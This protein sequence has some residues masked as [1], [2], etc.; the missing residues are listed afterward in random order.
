MRAG[1]GRQSVVGRRVGVAGRA[2]SKPLQGATLI[3]HSATAEDAAQ[4]VPAAG[5]AH[6]K[7]PVVAVAAA[8]AGHGCSSLSVLI[9]F[10]VGL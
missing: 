4:C 9:V 3:F 2:H 7:A 6:A 8:V 1:I 10:Y 5:D